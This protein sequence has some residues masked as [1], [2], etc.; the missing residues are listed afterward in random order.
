[1]CF[2]HPEKGLDDGLYLITFDHDVLYMATCHNSHYIVHLYVQCFV[3]RGG[4]EGDDDYCD[5]DGGGCRVDFNDPWQVDKLSDNDD[6]LDVDV[7]DGDDGVGP[8]KGTIN[9]N[10][11]HSEDSND[12]GVGGDGEEEEHM[13]GSHTVQSAE[14]MLAFEDDEKDDDTN[15][16]MGRSDILVSPLPSD[17]EDGVTSL[18]TN[19]DFH[20]VD[21]KDLVL[22]LH[23]KFTNLEQFREAV[24]EYNVK[25]GKD[26]CFFFF[27]KKKMKE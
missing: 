25:R 13:D 21:L 19:C 14:K 11:M 15:S 1:M 9:R 17:E 2:K 8:S 23:M 6:L 22:E 18:P 16:D 20:A 26:I 24:K 5:D 3:D 7:D 10:R 27:K 4:G 12:A